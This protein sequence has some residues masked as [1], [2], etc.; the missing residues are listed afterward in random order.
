MRIAL[1]VHRVTPD[2]NANLI[3]IIDSIH[4]CADKGVDLIIYSEAAITG[5]INNDDP[6]HDIHLGDPIPGKVTDT[7]AEIVR[8]RKIHLAI[9]IL[10]RE[11]NKLYDSAILFAPNGKIAMKYHRINPQWHGREA[12]P[13]VYCQGEELT[14]VS[15]DLGTFMFLICGDLFEDD[16]V[17]RVRKLKPDW[18]LVPFARCFDDGTYD[19]VRWDREEKFQYIARVKIAETP[20]FMVNYLAD[21]ELDGGSFGGA[22]AVSPTGEILG[23]LP[24]GKEGILYVEHEKSNR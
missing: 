24:I 5:L 22:M 7:L 20:T 19:Q 3:S 8:E 9:G 10:E 14:K 2:T 15:T 6:A 1:V 21:K 11:G 16:L 17:V 23:S 18:L 13:N 4:K 12:D